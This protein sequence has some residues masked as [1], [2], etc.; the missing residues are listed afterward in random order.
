VSD[1]IEFLTARLDEDEAA[2]T[3]AASCTGP[4]WHHSHAVT[5]NGATTIIFN[6]PD[7]DIEV[8]DTLR[9]DDEEI[10]PFIA[11]QDPARALRE[12]EAGR[13]ILARYKDCLARMENPDYSAVFARAQAREYEDFVLPN[14]LIRYSDHPDYRQEWKP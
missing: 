14:L 12:V 4:D 11:R 13:G 10:A 1:L 7:D 2:A 6:G 3:A 9:R 5:A 8:A